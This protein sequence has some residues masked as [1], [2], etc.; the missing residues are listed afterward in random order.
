VRILL[1]G[2]AN[3]YVGKGMAGGEIAIR[4]AAATPAQ[5]DVL[6]GNTV[7]YGATGGHLFVAGRAGERFAVRNSGARAVVEGTGDHGCEY[8]TQGVVVVLGET[9]RNFASGMSNGVAYVLDEFGD[10]AT[11]IQDP[12]IGLVRLESGLDEEL[13]AALIG[14]HVELTGSARGQTVLS[15][16]AHFGRRFWKV[17]ARAVVEGDAGGQ[18]LRRHLAELQ[19]GAPAGL[20]LEESGVGG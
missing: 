10:F 7:L 3:D 6:V 12:A 5:G 17:S 18:L 13:L 1:A 20:V 9:G 8:M 2:E 19:E 4:P 16:W 14:R 11:R 15:R